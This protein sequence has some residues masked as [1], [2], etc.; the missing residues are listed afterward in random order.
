MDG[1]DSPPAKRP[2]D[3]RQ[4][5]ALAAE[6]ATLKRIRDARSSDSLASTLFRR[7][8]QALCSGADVRKVALSITADAMVAIHLG[9]IDGE[10][11]AAAGLTT[12]QAARVLEASF[13]EATSTIEKLS[14]DLRSHIAMTLP[15]STSS[16]FFVEA[17]VRQ[18]RAGAT[19][20]GKARLILEPQEGHGDHCLVV[21][22]LGV[23]LCNDYDADPAIAFLAGLAHHL[24]NAT[25]PD[26]GYA[27]EMLL[28]PHLASVLQVLTSN[29]L[30]TL[31]P[32]LRA[33]VQDALAT[34]VDAGSPEGR[35]FN[36]ADVI[37]R[38]MEVRHFAAVARFTEAHALDEMQLVHEGPIQEFHHQVLLQAGLMTP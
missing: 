8:W 26:S 36:A 31:S 16:P 9:G 15:E 5:A 19:C 14:P 23:V 18:P 20:P 33:K 2:K 25:L 34:T 13:D 12:D 17:L 1:F 30:E 6:L 22:V 4:F 32:G 3:L 24:H 21:A 37:D 28:G 11:L 10:I 27:G 7:A 29:A 35:A 38:I